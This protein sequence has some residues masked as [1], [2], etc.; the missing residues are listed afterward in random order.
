[1]QFLR[2][3]VE[4]IKPLFEKGGK[5]EW[6]YFIWEAHETLLFQPSQTAGVKGAHVRDANDMKRMMV[7]V[8][9]AMIPVL[10]F[11]MWNVGDQYY[12]YF[13]ELAMKEF[14]VEN[15]SEPTFG[16]K[17]LYGA[18]RVIPILAVSYI[19][20]LTIEFTIASMRRHPIAEGYL[21]S[22]MLIPLVCP[23]TIP[24]WQI[25]IATAFSV[26]LAKEVFGGTGMNL[27][28]PALTARAFLFFAYPTDISG[29]LDVWVADGYAGPTALGAGANSMAGVES[30]VTVADFSFSDLFFGFIPGCIGETS[31]LLCLVGAAILIG[32]GVGSWRIMLSMLIGGLAMAFLLESV[33]E[34][35]FFGAERWYY[36]IVAG[37]FAFGLVFMATD[38]VYAAHTNKGKIIYG[39][40]AGVLGILIRVANP[41]YPEGIMLAI[42][43][44]NVVAPTIDYAVV[45]SNKNRRLRRVTV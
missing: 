25:A 14:I 45:S 3:K 36:H 23:P 12:A 38:P 44:M 7:T 42:L 24:L 1:M 28:N 6:F 32:T 4:E 16:D 20:G 22:G 17:F 29:G 39:F 19:V 31:T 5:L 30:A 11:G 43:L 8:I 41:A 35:N 15:G 13:S 37:G 34:I 27:L 26:I 33:V 18:I 21:V 10:L 2:E 9:L 40:L